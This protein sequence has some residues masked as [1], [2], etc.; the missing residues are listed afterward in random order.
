MDIY[1]EHNNESKKATLNVSAEKSLDFVFLGPIPDNNILGSAI[2][3]GRY[4]VGLGKVK[5]QLEGISSSGEMGSL[6]GQDI[7]GFC[8]TNK[9]NI[10]PNSLGIYPNWQ[11][12]KVVPNTEERD[13]LELPDAYE[14]LGDVSIASCS[15]IEGRELIK[16][17]TEVQD[18]DYAVIKYKWTN[19][20]G[21][22][23]DT[24]T[25]IS[26]PNRSN[27]GVVGWGRLAN[28]ADYLS[29]NDDNR[30]SGV[31][32]IL[33]NI[34]NL[35][36]DFPGQK[37]FVISLAAFWFDKKYSGDLNIEVNTYRGGTMSRSGYDWQNAGGTL[38]QNLSFDANTQLQIQE[39]E[40]AGTP[41]GVLSYNTDTKLGKLSNVPIENEEVIEPP[42]PPEPIPAGFD[43]SIYQRYRGP[44]VQFDLTMDDVTEPWKLMDGSNVICEHSAEP[45]TLGLHYRDGAFY[46]VGIAN[47]VLI[48]L[49]FSDTLTQYRL[50]T[51]SNNILFTSSLRD[52]YKTDPVLDVRI[53]NFSDN[54]TSYKFNIL[55]SLLHLPDAIPPTVTSMSSMFRGTRFISGDI[56][57]WD[58]SNVTNMEYAFA[59]CTDF[60]QD[61]SGW[62]VSN[63]TN[64]YRTFTGATA[65]NQDLSGW[66]VPSFDIEPALFSTGCSNWTL[67]KPVWGTCPGIGDYLPVSYPT[68]TNQFIFGIQRFENKP[69]KLTTVLMIE[70][71]STSWSIK[72]YL[73]GAVLASNTVPSID[74]TKVKFDFYNGK[75]RIT[76]TH[77]HYEK[78]VYELNTNGRVLEFDSSSPTVDSQPTSIVDVYSFSNVINKY[79][80]DLDGLFTV[81][82]YLP[83]NVV[84][85]AK[86]FESCNYF[87]S[88]ISNWD[89]SNVT[90]MSYMFKNAYRFESDLT[91]WNVSNVINMS[92]MFNYAVGFNGDISSWDVSNVTNMSYMFTDA[93]K[94]NQDISNWNVSG[95]TNMSEMFYNSY[96]FNQDIGRWNVSNV[97]NMSRLFNNA[98]DFNQDIGGWNVS[99]VTNM[100]YM[101]YNTDDFNQDLS[102]WCVPSITS[103]PESFDSNNPNPAWT[104]PKP[105][106]GTCPRGE[107]IAI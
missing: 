24:R 96:V 2:L 27:V 47:R 31:E 44:Q 15:Y 70:G 55:D 32:G 54:I 89:V 60:N 97:T 93:R 29:W 61:I 5:Y 88:D 13:P 22:D 43:F 69:T 84:D 36:R 49:P 41:L 8:L 17:E 86:M 18:F 94:F 82:N 75:L 87:G 53:I 76:I 100:D 9:P 71:Y 50:I 33:V 92:G 91:N 103:L 3:V 25:Y 107:N 57:G 62:D 66:C 90:T 98:Y 74:S 81:P 39:S 101:F 20:G 52:Q 48:R 34:L 42:E 58:V 85:T 106:W 19:Q 37:D 11:T 64:F 12:I 80:F 95:V 38:V 30:G 16:E 77:D 72:N 83:P 79:L 14:Y 105:V 23:L 6:N 40:T 10:D 35:K 56:T 59:G 4:D 51:E 28:D 46:R 1:Y 73:T 45:N 102:Q 104:L 65:F 63:V 26:T 78:H 21:K 68:N 99:N 7:I 67:P